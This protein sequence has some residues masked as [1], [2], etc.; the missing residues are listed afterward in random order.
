ML[1]LSPFLCRCKRI[2]PDI[3]LQPALMILQIEVVIHLAYYWYKYLVLSNNGRRFY[4]MAACHIIRQR[5]FQINVIVHGHLT[6]DV[7]A[8]IN[9]LMGTPNYLCGMW[10]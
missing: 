4:S 7:G 6:R 3:E 1:N 9:D 2:K 8:D 5:C 10:F